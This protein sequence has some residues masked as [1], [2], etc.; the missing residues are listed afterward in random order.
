MRAKDKFL[1]KINLI[2]L[3]FILCSAH[4]LNAENIYK[5]IFNYNNSLKNSSVN[6]I[7]TNP[8]QIQEGVIFFGDNRIKISYKKP[9]KLTII[10]SEKKGMYI[11]HDLEEVE[12]FITKKSYVKVFFDIFHKKNHIETMVV[13]KSNNQI[14]I[15]EKS[16]IDSDFF[17]ISVVYENG[18]IKLRRLEIIS[19]DEKIYMGFFDHK[20]EKVFDRKF[21]SMIDP[22]LN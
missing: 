4:N 16:Q 22:Y 5:K 7:Q 6:F 19:D 13:E 1:E 8:N 15:S 3:I 18:P 10:L 14:K 9:Q 21:F 20:N 17:S 11:N 2:I 12:F